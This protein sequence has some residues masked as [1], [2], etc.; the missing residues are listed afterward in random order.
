[1]NRRTIADEQGFILV[2][3]LLL[4]VVVTLLGASGISTSIF[5]TK[6]AANEALRKQ[7][8][9]QAD[10]GTE[11]SI[12]LLQNNINC[13]TGF[14]KTLDG[15]IVLA[16]TATGNTNPLGSNNF[17][18][19]NN[20]TTEIDMASD[21]DRDFYYPSSASAP[22]TTIPHTNGRINGS[23]KMMAGASLQQLAGYEGKGKGIGADGAYLVFD[24][25]L[26]RLGER[27]SRTGICLTYR[28][29]NQFASNPAGECVY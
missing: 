14:T 23:V 12:S 17:W 29:E 3:A 4:L 25:K 13:I 24:I 1:M 7:T 22:G 21:T 19:S 26:E 8:F 27:N 18:L 16:T 20:D 28:V 15:G 2:W 5:E 10:G 9:Y 6:M 11:N